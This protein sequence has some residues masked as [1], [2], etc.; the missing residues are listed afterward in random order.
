MTNEQKKTLTYRKKPQTSNMY[1]YTFFRQLPAEKP[2]VIM[3]NQKRPDPAIS[4]RK[5]KEINLS[6]LNH[7]VVKIFTILKENIISLQ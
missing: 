7:S 3:V 6:S 2:V 4:V 1:I 5:L